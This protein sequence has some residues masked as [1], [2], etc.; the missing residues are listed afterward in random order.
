MGLTKLVISIVM[1]FLMTCWLVPTSSVA[2]SETA[3]QNAIILDFKTMVGVDGPFLGN[4]NPINGVPGGGRPWVLEEGSG[5][6]QANGRL[7]IKVRGL[8]IP[9][10]EGPQ[11]G[12]NPVAFFRAILSCTTVDESGNPIILNTRTQNGA[13]VMI[14]D[15]RNGDAGIKEVIELPSPCLAP[16]IFVTSPTGA[17]FAVTG[18]GIIPSD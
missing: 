2:E 7:D 15:P 9:V 11:F 6:L 14:G 10:S 4:S 1:G 8:I 5:K 3:K 12:I 13:E 16:I 18:A 17:W